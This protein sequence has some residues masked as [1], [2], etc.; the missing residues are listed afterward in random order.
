MIDYL[1]ARQLDGPRRASRSRSPLPAASI[2]PPTSSSVRKCALQ[3]T[4]M[5]AFHGQNVPNCKPMV[6]GG[7]SKCSAGACPPLGSGWGVAES[8]VPIR[9]TKPQ[10]RLFIPRCAGSS[11]H[12]TNGTKIVWFGFDSASESHQSPVPSFPRKR[13]SREEGWHQPH[14]NTSNDQ[15]SF[16]YL[17]VPAPAG[18][19]DW[20]E[21]SVARLR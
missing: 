2:R 6:D 17:G 4:S 13:E 18:M 7:M 14:P 3:S 12:E 11:R 19:S 8:A 10:L 9:C 5:P 20:Y 21:N 15:V 1:S 16:S